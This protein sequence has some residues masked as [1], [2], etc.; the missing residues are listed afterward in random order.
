M[1]NWNLLCGQK[2]IET[3][4]LVEQNLKQFCDVMSEEETKIQSDSLVRK[5]LRD[6]S[7]DLT[8]RN[9]RL[10][11]VDIE[12]SRIPCIVQSDFENQIVKL[13]QRKSTSKIDFT[14]DLSRL[15]RT[16]TEHERILAAPD[17]PP[18]ESFETNISC[19]SFRRK[20]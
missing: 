2:R 10:V 4:P 14:E 6:S 7:D 20:K 13:E 1:W 11:R 3:L 18:K 9:A 16:G 8:V 15:S 5:W 17:E 12:S 19:F